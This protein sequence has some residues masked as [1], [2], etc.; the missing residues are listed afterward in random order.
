MHG[1]MVFWI[2]SNDAV[3]AFSDKKTHGEM[4][5]NNKTNIVKV[6]AMLISDVKTL[7]FQVSLY[8]NIL[9]IKTILSLS[10]S[11]SI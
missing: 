3:K 11:L 8:M 1:W 4:K 2:Y 10:E 7:S 9:S 6:H 5:M